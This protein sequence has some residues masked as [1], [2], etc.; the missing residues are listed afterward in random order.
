MDAF[1]PR[2]QGDSGLSVDWPGATLISGPFMPTPSGPRFHGANGVRVD[3]ADDVV[4][5]DPF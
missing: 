2:F 1:G 5:C 3:L 4:V